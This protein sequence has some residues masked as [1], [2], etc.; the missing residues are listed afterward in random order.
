MSNCYFENASSNRIDISSSCIFWFRTQ[1][2]DRK[3]FKNGNRA[4]ILRTCYETIPWHNI[5]L[6]SSVCRIIR[7]PKKKRKTLRKIRQVLSLSSSRANKSRQLLHE[8]KLE[9]ELLLTAQF[10]FPA[11]E[12]DRTINMYSRSYFLNS[13]KFFNWVILVFHETGAPSEGKENE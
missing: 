10:K 1:F 13:W 4:E 5:P 11:W 12:H 6:K 8:I 9:S 2:L 7:L 3:T